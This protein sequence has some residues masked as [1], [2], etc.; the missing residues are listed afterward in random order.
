LL[1]LNNWE[2]LRNNNNRVR[3]YVNEGTRPDK[4]TR[5]VTS[6][7]ILYYVRDGNDKAR[8]KDA[9]SFCGAPRVRVREI[10]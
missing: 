3:T 8:D 4:Y 10:L 2:D 1:S 5:I 7:G 9:I 6:I